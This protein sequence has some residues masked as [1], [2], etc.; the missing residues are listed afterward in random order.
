MPTYQYQCPDCK[1]E[2]ETRQ[3]FKDKPQAA[4]PVCQGMAQRLFIPVPIVFKGA[5]FYV[6]DSKVNKV[7]SCKVPEKAEKS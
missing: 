1:L 4:C 5:G 7:N 6:N 3:N 2:F